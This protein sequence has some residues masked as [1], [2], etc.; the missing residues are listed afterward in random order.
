FKVARMIEGGDAGSSPI[1]VRHIDV[2]HDDPGL[3][4]PLA[5]DVT[6][7]RYDEAVPI[8]CPAVC[9]PP[10]LRRREDET[11]VFDGA[12]AQKNVPMLFAR[13]LREGRR[14]GEEFR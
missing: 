4:S 6:P 8:R 3:R 13:D 7:W 11:A 5:E 2:G 14:R 10:A 12:G 9:V 1:H